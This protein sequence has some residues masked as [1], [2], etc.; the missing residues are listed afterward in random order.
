M[1]I[2]SNFQ[3][4]QRTL[5]PPRKIPLA[6][7]INTGDIEEAAAK[8]AQASANEAQS[9]S[10][11]AHADIAKSR[12]IS[13]IANIAA[14]ADEQYQNNMFYNAMGQ[15]QGIAKNAQSI[16]THSN[17]A[18]HISNAQVA[19][20]TAMKGLH[21]AIS[22]TMNDNERKE[23]QAAITNYSGMLHQ[24]ATEKKNKISFDN[25]Y[26]STVNGIDPYLKNVSVNWTQAETPKQRQ[27]ILNSLG[28]KIKQLE[29]LQ[30]SAPTPE[31]SIK[32]S[33]L[34]RK[35]HS[36]GAVL[37]QTEEQ[38]TGPITT[39]IS[40][41]VSNQ[42]LSGSKS[43]DN[44][45]REIMQGGSPRNS[46]DISKESPDNIINDF[47][48]GKTI[49]RM[50]NGLAMSS[51]VVDDVSHWS[52]SD[53]PIQKM[54]GSYYQK[55]INQG[56]A[57]DALIAIN[58]NGVLAR[59]RK[60]WRDNMTPDNYAA[61]KNTLESEAAH[62]GVPVNKIDLMPDEQKEAISQTLQSGLIYDKN[63]K[64]VGVKPS[65]NESQFKYIFKEASALEGKH[66]IMGNSP[67]VQGFNYARFMPLTDSGPQNEQA[68]FRGMV[69]FQPAVQQ[70]LA[71]DPDL[72]GK[73]SEKM[74]GLGVKSHSE[75]LSDVLSSP[76][77]Y[78]LDELSQIT[79]MDR[80]TLGKS[81][82]AQIELGVKS[83]LKDTEANAEVR[84]SLNDMMKTHKTINGN[85]G[86]LGFF[87]VQYSLNSDTF[88]KNAG[89]TATPEEIDKA[90]PIIMKNRL[91][92][93]RHNEGL[94]FQEQSINTKDPNIK[95]KVTE[96]DK[97]NFLSQT[98]GD[99][100]EW[101][102][103]TSNGGVYMKNGQNKM[104]QIDPMM[105]QNAI[106]KVKTESAQEEVRKKTPMTPLQYLRS[107]G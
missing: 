88:N 21:D 17:D 70:S 97:E 24:Q 36:L 58:P 54:V 42:I 96:N 4:V 103:V 89:S 69:S 53:N 62:R 85:T 34:A 80:V 3:K 75:L 90:V 50:R 6:K 68:A 32:I 73:D 5:N 13:S 10:E 51:H 43:S 66:T 22:P 77:V 105:I 56:R 71:T 100:S 82:T 101:S 2:F 19:A 18:D 57:Q 8:S 60:Q 7:P 98:V 38:P 91:D 76:S 86:P 31:R 83:G 94:K 84:T 102:L 40:T 41:E 106:N 29:V 65:F 92:L 63:D 16:I 107:I 78:N 27:E 33:N 25:S 59:A 14:K 52:N 104:I 79:G 48:V 23:V 9:F 1:A 67:E 12:D 46:L 35:V 47:E 74:K 95:K 11:E 15:V 72:Y 30:A 20:A 44:Y 45:Y 37:T 39:D 64:V 93:Y 28:G 87:G 61:Y 26:Y 99:E 81:I 49:Q 55:L